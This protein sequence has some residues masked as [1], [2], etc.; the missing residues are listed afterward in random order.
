METVRGEQ[1]TADG[2]EEQRRAVDEVLMHG[3]D[4]RHVVSCGAISCP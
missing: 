4:V 2:Y 3:N 1:W